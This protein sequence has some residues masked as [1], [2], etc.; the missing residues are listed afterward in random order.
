MIGSLFPLN[1][2]IPM[3]YCSTTWG[4][5]LWYLCQFLYYSEYFSYSVLLLNVCFCVSLFVC[6]CFHIR[7]KIILSI[8][9]NFVKNII[10]IIFNLLHLVMLKWHYINLIVP[11]SLEMFL[12][13]TSFFHDLI[14]Y[15]TSISLPRLVWKCLCI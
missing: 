1:D 9:L 2:F 10:G 12:F 13:S 7:M 15:Y 5:R 14:F 4:W 11:Y 3:P 8:S 6:V